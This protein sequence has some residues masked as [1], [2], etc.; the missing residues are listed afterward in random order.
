MPFLCPP[1]LLSTPNGLL[2]VLQRYQTHLYSPALHF[3]SFCSECPSPRYSY[4]QLPVFLH[5]WLQS[6]LPIRAFPGHSIKNIYIDG[7]LSLKR[8]QRYWLILITTVS[9]SSKSLPVNQRCLINNYWINSFIQKWKSL[10]AHIHT[11]YLSVT[12]L[13]NHNLENPKAIFWSWL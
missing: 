3:C 4:S 5:D 6:Y 10:S 12:N 9:L 7:F 1:S 11:S 13:Q 8:G 2:A